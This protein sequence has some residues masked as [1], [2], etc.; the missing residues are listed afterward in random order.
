MSGEIDPKR[1]AQEFYATALARERTRAGLTQAQLGAK[2]GVIVSSQ[3]IG[4]IENCR[5]PPTLRFS[6]ALDQSLD[7]VDYFEGLYEAYVRESGVP[8]AFWEYSEQECF[9][10][11]IKTY[12]NFA[13]SGLLQSVEYAR[14]IMRLKQGP[15]D[16]EKAVATRMSRQEVLRREDPPWFFAILDEFAVRRIVGNK[17]VTRRQLE[18]VIAAMEEPNISVA[19]LP[20]GA[21]VYPASGFTVLRFANQDDLAYVE[22]ANGHGKIVEQ[23]L[24][25][26]ELAVLFD[27]L[28]AAALSP[29]D[30]AKLIRTVMEDL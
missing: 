26:S 11:T 10:S 16:L 14:E 20:N 2:P 19:V 9:A 22:A 18:Q 29:D 23:G 3:Q 17:D 25:T 27:R 1:S 30:S 21:L 12:G 7:L 15:E 8:Q 6:R 4:H 28:L 13:I 24:P 5:R